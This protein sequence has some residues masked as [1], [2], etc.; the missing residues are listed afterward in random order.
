MR[1]ETVSAKKRVIAV[2]PKGA[3]AWCYGN[4]LSE[5]YDYMEIGEIVEVKLVEMTQ[6]E[7]DAM[8]EFEGW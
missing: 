8:P 2:R 3:T 7:I 1:L 6:A 5:L 4:D